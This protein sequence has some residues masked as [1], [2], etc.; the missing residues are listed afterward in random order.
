VN[1][2][3]H[4]SYAPSLRYETE[5]PDTHMD[6]STDGVWRF[7]VSLGFYVSFFDLN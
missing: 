3:V 5:D 7:G 4:G 6:T 2:S 1:V